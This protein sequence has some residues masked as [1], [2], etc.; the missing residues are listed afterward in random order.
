MHRHH[1]K[2]KKH[3]REEEKKDKGH[4]RILGKLY[5]VRDTKE[6]LNVIREYA[7][8]ALLSSTTTSMVLRPYYYIIPFISCLSLLINLF[9]S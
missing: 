8:S 3:Q 5:K 7:A 2:K 6:G 4:E 9:I 1:H